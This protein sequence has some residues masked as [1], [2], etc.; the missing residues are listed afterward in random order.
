VL[1]YQLSRYQKP[2]AFT[3]NYAEKHWQTIVISIDKFSSLQRSLT[4][5]MLF[6]TKSAVTLP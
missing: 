1:D 4:A 6:Y 3:F 5:S 2:P